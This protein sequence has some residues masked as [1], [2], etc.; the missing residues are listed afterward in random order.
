MRR[1]AVIAL[2]CAGC[3]SDPSPPSSTSPS[4]TTAITDTVAT[5]DAPTTDA[6]NTDAAGDPG[7]EGDPGGPGE[8]AADIAGTEDAAAPDCTTT[9]KAAYCACTEAA[10]CETGYCVLSDAGKVC[11]D[12]CISKCPSGWSCEKAGLPGSGADDEYIC[13]QRSVFLCKPC[14]GD[15]ECTTLGTAGSQCLDYGDEGRFCGLACDLEH[16]CPDG[17]DCL[18]GQCRLTTGVCTCAPLHTALEAKTSCAVSNALGSCPGNRKCSSEG[19]TPCDAPA[20]AEESCDGADN[21]CD[22]QTDEAVTTPCD[23]KNAFGTCPGTIFCQS[24]V[25]ICQGAPPTAES[26]D[27]G[28]NDCDGKVDEGFPDSDG[29]TLSDCTDPD[30]DDDGKIDEK[31]NCPVDP[32]KDQVDTDADEKGDAC[33]GDDDGDGVPDGQD[34]K[35]LVKVVYPFAPELCDGVDNDCDGQTDEKSCNDDNACTDDVCDPVSGCSYAFNTSVCNDQNP[36]TTGD[37][38]SAG[39]CAG[40]FLACNDQNPCTDDACNALVG[41]QNV[42]NALA[43]S[44]GSVCTAGDACSGG[45]CLPGAPLACDDGNP[46]TLDSC[47]ATSGCQKVPLGGACDDG[48]ACTKGDVC[49]GGACTGVFGSCDDGNACTLDSCDVVKGCLHEA[50]PGGLCDDGNACTAA[51]HCDTGKCVG[52]DA[53]CECE[54]DADCIGFED[55]NLC[56]GTLHCDKTAAP[57][58]C[59]VKPGTTVSCPLPGGLNSACATSVCDPGSG[60]CGTKIGQDDL[61]CSDGS[62]CTQSDHCVSG[63]CQGLT[64]ACN[65]GNACTNDL[66]DPA[67]GC[68]YEAVAGFKTCEDGNACT[69]GDVCEGG[70]CT[71]KQAVLCNDGN[72]CTADVCDT[73]TGCKYTP[74]SGLPCDDGSLC[75]TFDACLTSVCTG[76]PLACDNGNAC[77]GKEICDP[78]TGCVKGTAL[79]CDDS[80]AC[81]LDACDPGTGCQNVPSNAAC[82]DKTFCNGAETCDAKAGC[83]AGPVPVLSDGIDCTLDACDEGLDKVVHAP[84]D[85]ACEDGNS[86]TSDT[87]SATLACLHVTLQDAAPCDDGDGCTVS[88]ACT[89]GACVGGQSC[90]AVGQLCSA[91]QCVG[92]GS[93]SIR[94]VSVA[95]VIKGATLRARIVSTPTVGGS[96]K[97]TK[98]ESIFSALAR[99]MG[100]W[101]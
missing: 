69:K 18:D 11:A 59:A 73:G 47:D 83:K 60:L 95:G 57:F 79:K 101:K 43:C 62:A 68:V 91:G 65:D 56:N 26:C 12:H 32:N 71:G 35:P 13:V 52:D 33:D 34:C 28:D 6:P 31:D 88:E 5:A 7:V 27:G 82:D 36:C 93:A 53:G 19:L 10:D 99:A 96:V 61:I 77:D 84:K 50:T 70:T 41:C 76:T 45:V 97:G 78:A 75:T 67:K 44:D 54:K 46:C 21:D 100:L 86:C 66:C 1:A 74:T 16:P 2:L 90:A 85:A 24:G 80:V 58:A 42:P 89:A 72:A 81:T 94:F 49:T 3:G 51:D 30:D 14:L 39:S 29:D 98:T 64:T 40:Q 23:I 87:C 17:F 37:G 55:G 63:T 48:N 8:D 25:G 4:D 15:A 22:G 9:P 92:G 20:P 38:C